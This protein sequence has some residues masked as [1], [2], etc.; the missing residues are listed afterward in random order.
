MLAQDVRW[1][2]L[3]GPSSALDL[4]W[5]LD[6][7][8]HLHRVTRRGGI[9]VAIATHGMNLAARFCDA[10]VAPKNDACVA[11]SPGVEVFTPE[12]LGR[13]FDVP[14]RV[15]RDGNHLF[16]PPKRHDGKDWPLE[17]SFSL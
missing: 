14:M 10:I 4:V 11:H 9:G 1:L 5:M 3:D 6:M 7:L 16:A 2:L 8:T 13:V 12:T 15:F 17:A